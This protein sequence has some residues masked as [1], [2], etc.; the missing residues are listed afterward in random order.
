VITNPDVV[1][2][3]NGKRVT[4]NAGSAWYLRLS[5][6]HSVENK[7]TTDRVH[8]LIDMVMNDRLA[9]I[10]ADAARRAEIHRPDSDG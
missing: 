4:M 8:L 1:F 9:G 3:L 10:L 2:L 6:P 5:E 7:G